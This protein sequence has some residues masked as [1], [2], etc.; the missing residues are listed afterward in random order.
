VEPS[1]KPGRVRLRRDA[2]PNRAIFSLK[3]LAFLYE[4]LL[5]LPVGILQGIVADEV[6]TFAHNH[7]AERVITIQT[8]DPRFR[9]ILRG[10]EYQ[11][12]VQ[13]LPVPSFVEG[14]ES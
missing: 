14:L 8:T 13:V 5:D 1:G 3:H 9:D 2:H 6:V 12:P 4:C 10:I 7:Q 11:L